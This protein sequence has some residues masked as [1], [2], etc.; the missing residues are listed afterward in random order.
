MLNDFAIGEEVLE[1]SE[2]VS[3]DVDKIQNGHPDKI[4]EHYNEEQDNTQTSQ[5]QAELSQ[6]K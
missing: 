3:S 4:T 5:S 2:K 1:I 6:S